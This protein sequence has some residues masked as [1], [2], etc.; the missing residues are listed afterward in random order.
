MGQNKRKVLLFLDNAAPHPNLKMKN[1]EL[2]IFLPNMT[3]LANRL[4]K[5]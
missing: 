3:S 1:I 4:T 2:V 5:E